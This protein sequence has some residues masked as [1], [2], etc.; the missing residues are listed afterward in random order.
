MTAAHCVADAETMK[1]YLGAHNVR[2]E[3]EEGRLEFESTNFFAHPKWNSV[4]IK[5]DIGLIQLPEKVE[6]NEIIRP[7][8]LPSY[9]DE[10]DKFAG[11]DVRKK[12]KIYIKRLTNYSIEF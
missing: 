8:C 4:T 10:D 7:I 9:S 1:V 11:L 5:N 6:F 12:N 2:E 3:S